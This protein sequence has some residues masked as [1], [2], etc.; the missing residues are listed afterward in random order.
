MMRPRCYYNSSSLFLL[1]SFSSSS[2]LYFSSHSNA[3]KIQS[4]FRFSS[5]SSSS[6]SQK[7]E[8]LSLTQQVETIIRD[9][10]NGGKSTQILANA[11]LLTKPWEASCIEVH[12]E[13]PGTQTCPIRTRSSTLKDTSNASSSVSEAKQKEQEEEMEERKKKMKS[14]IILYYETHTDEGLAAFRAVARR[15]SEGSLPGS[16]ENRSAFGFAMWKCPADDFMI[17]NTG[18]KLTE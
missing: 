1:S 10:R 3:A 18:E 12:S 11:D 8:L 13:I 17:L 9:S 5:S 14:F 7:F 4:S 6:S 15:V 2:S 16:V